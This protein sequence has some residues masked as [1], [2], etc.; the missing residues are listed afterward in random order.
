MSET[1]PVLGIITKLKA[2]ASIAGMVAA[3]VFGDELPGSETASMPRKCIVVEPAGGS[4]SFGRAYQDYSDGRFDIRCYGETPYQAGV[5]A[6][7][8][9][10]AMKHLDREVHAGVLLHWAIRSGGP[11]SLRDPD[12]NWPFRFESYQVLASEKEIA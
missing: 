8:V 3:R 4:Q 5:L 6:R 2:N 11:L 10:T 12:A 7:A 9:H 1:D